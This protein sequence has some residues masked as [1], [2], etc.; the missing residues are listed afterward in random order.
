MFSRRAKPSLSTR[1]REL[2]W[3]QRGWGRK[4]RYLRLRM[5]R[6]PDTPNRIALGI[7]AGVLV[8]FTPFFGAH[9]VLAVA[10]AW[11]IRGNIIASLLGTLIANPVTFPL[12]ALA[13]METGRRILGEGAA[14]PGDEGL[15]RLFSNAASELWHNFLAI[16]TPTLTH[17]GKFLAF[18]DSVMIPYLV[19]GLLIGTICAAVCFWLTRSAVRVYQTRRRLRL[20]TQ[21]HKTRSKPNSPLQ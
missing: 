10:L 11:I 7:A 9:T 15:T 1:L 14:Y 5:N 12:I 18:V 8:S 3:P 13:S 6:I 20:R 16:F 4:L 17:W 19:G 2:M 21:S